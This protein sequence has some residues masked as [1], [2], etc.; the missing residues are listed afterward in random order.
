MTGKIASSGALKLRILDA[1]ARARQRKAPHCPELSAACVALALHSA[2]LAPHWP[3]IQR[4]L[5]RTGA[6]TGA[7]PVSR[8]GSP[9]CWVR[10]RPF[11]TGEVFTPTVVLFLRRVLW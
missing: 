4:G 1:R 3:C 10:M 5:R 6:R 2:R 7:A 8:G 9:V 11:V